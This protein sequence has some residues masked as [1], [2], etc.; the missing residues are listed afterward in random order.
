MQLLSFFFRPPLWELLMKSHSFLKTSREYV[1]PQHGSRRRPMKTPAGL[2]LLSSVSTGA[3]EGLRDTPESPPG[4]GLGL[5]PPSRPLF[6]L[7]SWLPFGYWPHG[8]PNG[9]QVLPHAVP[10]PSP[11][12]HL[13]GKASPRHRRLLPSL[14]PHLYQ[15][16]PLLRRPAPRRALSHFG[17]RHRHR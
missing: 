13:S 2:V 15:E 17:Q 5:L 1:C 3:P 10:P 8:P 14:L 16:S 6:S 11:R 4:P 9:R 12:R 7:G